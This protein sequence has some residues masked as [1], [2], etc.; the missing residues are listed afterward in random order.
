LTEVFNHMVGRLRQ[1][2]QELDAMNERLRKQNE[3]LELLSTSDALTGLHNR[4]SLTQRLAAELSRSYRQKTSFTVLMADVDEFKKYND[5]YGHPAGDEVLKRVANI[6]LS[7]TRAVDCTARYGGEE[8]A[9]LLTD[10]AGDEALEVAER[11]RSRVA[12]GEFPSRK[13]TLSIGMAEFPQDGFTADVVISNA[14]EALYEAKRG[15]RNRVVRAGPKSG[16]P[17]EKKV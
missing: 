9:V 16:K 7:C 14:D 5:A 10:T 3:E 8:F 15:G 11:I 2:R 1:G 12:E 6:L 17:A 13:I 4:R